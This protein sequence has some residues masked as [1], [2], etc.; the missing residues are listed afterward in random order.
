MVVGSYLD[1]L[2]SRRRRHFFQ[3]GLVIR[4]MASTSERAPPTAC[5]WPCRREQALSESGE[6]AGAPGPGDA[7]PLWPRRSADAPC[8]RAARGWHREGGE[9]WR[10]HSNRGGR[11]GR[12]VSRPSREV[13]INM[14]YDRDVLR[15]FNPTSDF[16]SSPC[17]LAGPQRPHSV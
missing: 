1:A 11:K 5:R 7:C 3:A 12:A 17:C 9:V 13:I 10:C 8:G 6:P 14:A 4:P 2:R 16:E 15:I